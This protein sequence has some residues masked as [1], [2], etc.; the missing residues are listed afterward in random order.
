MFLAK[1][2][3]VSR[4]SV[5]AETRVLSQSSLCGICGERSGADTGFPLNIY[6]YVVPFSFFLF[7][8][9]LLLR[10]ILFPSIPPIFSFFFFLVLSVFPLIVYSL[11][12]FMAIH[13]LFISSFLYFYLVFSFLVA[14]LQLSAFPYAG[15]QPDR[16]T[17][18]LTL[19]PPCL[20]CAIF[21]RQL[22]LLQRSLSISESAHPLVAVRMNKFHFS[23]LCLIL[24]SS[25]RLFLIRCLQHLSH[26]DQNGRGWSIPHLTSKNFGNSEKRRCEVP[27]RQGRG[28][29]RC[30]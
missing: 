6:S 25:S 29:E 23:F 2:R 26:K 22:L 30:R 15:G 14:A 10:F 20:Y 19:R 4:L 1:A 12:R 21:L 8:Y 3:G 28:T 9:L 13:S 5:A 7:Y 16:S 11:L 24:L 18:A 17:S 27:L